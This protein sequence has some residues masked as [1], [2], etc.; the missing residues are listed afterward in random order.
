VGAGMVAGPAEGST[1]AL[2]LGVH[3]AHAKNSDSL[4]QLCF[5]LGRPYERE[6]CT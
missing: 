4:A 6:E 5:L 1:R 2:L 3:R